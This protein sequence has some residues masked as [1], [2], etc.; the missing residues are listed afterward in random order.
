MNFK[1]TLLAWAIPTA[2]YLLPVAHSGYNLVNAM[3]LSL[4]TAQPLF[5][6]WY[7]LPEKK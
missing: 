4:V 1:A 3:W 6:Y 5:W 2:L 7:F